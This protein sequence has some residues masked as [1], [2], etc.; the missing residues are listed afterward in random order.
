MFR[1]RGRKLGEILLSQGLV[2]EEQLQEA[3]VNQRT[4]GKTLGAVLVEL[5]FIS[6]DDLSFVLG[7]QIMLTSNKRLGEVLVDH[8]LITEEQLVKGLVHQKQKR[9][10]I[11]ES[12]VDLGYISEQKLID[13]LSAQLDVQ[14]VIVEH[15]K[16]KPEL[17]S[18]FAI[19]LCRQYKILPVYES[20][21]VITIAMTD[22]SDLRVRDHIKFMTGKDI[23]AVIASEKEIIKAIERVYRNSGPDMNQLIDGLSDE[24]TSL[25]IAADVEEDESLTDDE[26][27]Q[28]VKVVNFVLHD[29]VEKGCS[30][31]H[32]EPTD[33]GYLIKYR[34]DGDLSAQQELPI[35]MRPMIISRLKIQ[36]GM[37]ISEK[38]KPQDGRL[39]IRHQGR[40]VD[41]RVSSFPAMTRQTMS[42]KLVLRIIDSD[43][44]NFTLPQLGLSKET[45]AT[46]EELIKLPDGVILVTGPTGSGKSSTLYAGLRFVNNYHENKECIITMEDP[47]ES[48]VDGITQGQINPKAGFTFAAGMRSILRQDPDIIM[49]GEMRDTETAEMAIQAALTGHLVFSTLHTN[50]SPSAYTRLFDM[51]VAPYLV[52]T[53]IRGI[54]A[55]RLV[56]KL[57][58]NCK[59]QYDP[60][61]EILQRIGLRQGI[62]LWRGKGCAK[63]DN[64][65]YKG[66]LGLYELLVPDRN[67]Q[68]LVIKKSESDEIKD[69]LVHRGDFITLRKDGLIK[70]TQG[71][72]TVE[73]VMAAT[74]EGH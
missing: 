21:G 39:K 58:Q 1:R 34:V 19:D 61:P 52:S 40:N 71:L 22:P 65:G 6:A 43:G 13:V 27:Q 30:D 70:A 44:N 24:K 66:R 11:G 10:K 3:M 15:I 31:I 4:S 32:F 29:A 48:K 55:Q 49:I 42:E 46:F 54:M 47:V 67:V 28:V 53:A 8:G 41:F 2:T 36:C 12:L 23:D 9:M 38:R 16:V 56:R 50:D 20:N 74:Q 33:T 26:G 25:E 68:K 73:Q 37:D 14:H 45:M 18:L 69:Y 5:S 72:T 57:C 60:D 62:K 64:T 63:C 7:E 59:E 17:K 35:H 51:G